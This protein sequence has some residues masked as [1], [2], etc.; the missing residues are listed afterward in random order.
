LTSTVG[1]HCFVATE[2]IERGLVAILGADFS[3][4]AGTP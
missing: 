3:F 1:K 2:R 4:G